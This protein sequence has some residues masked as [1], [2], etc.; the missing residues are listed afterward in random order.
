MLF[1]FGKRTTRHKLRQVIRGYQRLRRGG[2]LGFVSQIN[3]DLTLVRLNIDISRVP[4]FVFGR[5]AKWAEI[6]ARQLLLSRLAGQGLNSAILSHLANRNDQVAYPLPGVWI[7]RLSQFGIGISETRSKALFAIFVSLAFARGVARF[8]LTLAGI[9]GSKPPTA[10]QKYV[11]FCDLAPNNLPRRDTGERFD[12]VSWY[13][14][15]SGKAEGLRAVRHT[16]PSQPDGDIDGVCLMSSKSDLP[17]FVGFQPRLRYALWGMCSIP[18]AIWEAVYGRWESALLFG[19]AAIARKVNLL[20]P[21]C[22][23]AEYLFSMSG[24]IQRPLWTYPAERMGS[25]VTLY[26]YSAGMRFCFK[27]VAPHYETGLQS[28]TWPRILVFSPQH[29]AFLARAVDFSPRIELVPPINFSDC[30]VDL[31]KLSQRCIAVFDVSPA[32]MSFR[33]SLAPEDD[34]RTA[35][36]GIRFLEEIYEV[37]SSQGYSMMWKK[38]RS[39]SSIHHEGY[40]RFADSFGRRS[41]VVEI[42]PDIAAGRVINNCFAAISM[43]FT[44][45]GFL[46][47]NSNIPSVFYDPVGAVSSDDPAA[48]GVPLISG[49]RDLKQWISQIT[50]YTAASGCAS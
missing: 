19:E 39:T 49:I 28:M 50:S 32:R 24:I 30:D 44:S 42:H 41:G 14:G 34:Y 36:V 48:H 7:E 6:A 27:G 12:I 15:W 13:L 33:A 29:K 2:D 16:V 17:D 35:E 25:K 31:P 1:G 26:C 20:D 23:A 4:E 10:Q 22:L 11:H 18:Y 43:P 37:L 40:I 5:E 38:K 46:A 21:E 47:K 8:L 45:T 3:Q 9:R